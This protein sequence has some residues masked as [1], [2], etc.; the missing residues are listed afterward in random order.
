MELR[1]DKSKGAISKQLLVNEQ[2]QSHKNDVVSDTECKK[3]ESGSG[4][5]NTT[6][7]SNKDVNDIVHA[8]ICTKIIKCD[9]IDD[10]VADKI[11]I[12]NNI[13]NYNNNNNL[14]I[15][16]DN[17]INN[18]IDIHN[19]LKNENDLIS[20]NSNRVKDTVSGGLGGCSKIPILNSNLRISKCA[21]WAGSDNNPNI[22]SLTPGNLSLQIIN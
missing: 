15:N 17:N 3:D 18:N 14:N 12:N 13:V 20:N 22:S 8:D 10:C 4:E 1:D 21:S 2:Q 7:Y 9:A 11:Q 6:A 16:N 19:S 5:H